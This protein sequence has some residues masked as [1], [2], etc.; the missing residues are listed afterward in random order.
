MNESESGVYT[1][2]D[3][4]S[5]SGGFFAK[6]DQTTNDEEDDSHEDDDEEQLGEGGEDGVDDNLVVVP[7]PKNFMSPPSIMSQKHRGMQKSTDK[8]MR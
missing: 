6:D 8:N 2:D 1:K 7:F 5:T 3:N 4:G